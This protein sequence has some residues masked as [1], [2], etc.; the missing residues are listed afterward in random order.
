MGM[1]IAR[2]LGRLPR[3][4]QPRMR[5]GDRGR[6]GSGCAWDSEEEKSRPAPCTTGHRIWWRV[7][8]RERRGTPIDVV[9]F[10]EISGKGGLELITQLR[11]NL[12]RAIAARAGNST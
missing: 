6:C 9:S 3:H 1:R 10:E 2:V 12:N 5:L 4:S 11:T 7:V 8:P